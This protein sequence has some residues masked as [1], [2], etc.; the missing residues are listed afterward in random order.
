MKKVNKLVIVGG[1]SAGWITASWFSRRWG[2]MIDV[3]I[4]DKYQPERVGVGEATLLSFPSVMQS[5]GF[6]VEDWINR[7]DATFKAGIL[8]PGWGREDKVIWH[9]FGFTSIG[10]NKVPMYDIWS[11]YQSKYDV[12]EISPLYRTAMGNKIELDYI[13]DTYAYQIDCG[14]L[15]TFLHDNCNRI[16]NYIQSDV[17]TVVKVDD[18]VEKIILEDGSEIKAD[19]FI[20][21]TGWNQL[22]IGKEDNVDLSD[23]LF[24]D[25]AL[26]A[27][28]KYENPDKEMHPYTDCQAMEHGW[29]WRIPTRSR[30]GTGYCFNRDVNDPDEVR[31]SFSDH[32]NGRIKPDEMRLLDW[33]PQYVKNF[34]EGNVVP[35]GLSAGFIEPL[36][37]TGLALMIRGVEYLEEGI[38]GG[39]FDSK[40]EAPFY[41]AKMKCSYESAVDYVNM[42]YSYCQRKG[43]FWDYVR[44]KYQKSSMQEMMEGY[45]QDPNIRT[46]QTGKVGSFFDGTNW[47]VWLLQLMTTEIN[48]KEYWK[49]DETALPRYENFLNHVLPD[50][51]ANSVIQSEYINHIDSLV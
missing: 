43:K 45:I 37:S 38:F 8:F 48:P 22:L 28:V 16:C 7:I 19:L 32:W 14:K 27:R 30:I 20:D 31:Q 15:V 2:K 12:K 47:H 39:Y 13:K 46:P 3:T 5:M 6:K 4:I 23:R 50:N 35:I 11:N 42:H 51:Q 24:I 18:D 36:E 49:K 21:C 26:A 40:V 17:K 1:G 9:P 33:K 41:D 29:R 44:S 25:S 34:W 10:D